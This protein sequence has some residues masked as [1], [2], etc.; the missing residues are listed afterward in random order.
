MDKY[1]AANDHYCYLGTSVLVNKL[2]ITDESVLEDAERD[3]TNST[4]SN[5]EYQAPPYNMDYFKKLH[6]QLFS[7][8]YDWAGCIRIVDIS[9][10]GTRFCN[11]SRVAPES[12][13]LFLLLAKDNWLQN[14]PKNELCSKLAEYYCEFNM[15]H[16][17]REGNGRVQRVFFEHLAL[18]VGYEL[19]WSDIT[20]Q[21]WIDAN[22]DGVNV[23]YAPM[24]AIFQRVLS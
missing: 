22:I 16:P 15:I 20:Q 11:C 23:N 3:I 1:D 17:F 21:E 2:N 8:L 9:K 10:G 4:I 7:V 24:D 19:D 13:K 14:L 6:T 12:E 5:I 18:S